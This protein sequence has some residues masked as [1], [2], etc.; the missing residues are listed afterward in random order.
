MLDQF[1]TRLSSVFG[2]LLLL[3][4]VFG[5]LAHAQEAPAN[6]YDVELSVANF[7]VGGLAREGDWAGIQVQV[8]DH[9]SETRDLVLRMS[10]RDAD[11][12]D[13]QYDRVITA[14]AGVQQSFWLYCWIP[15]RS[16]QQDFEIKAYEAID[17]GGGDSGG[18]GFRAGVMVG[19]VMVY[20][21]RLEPATV[22]FA[23]VLGNNQLGLDQYGVSVGNQLARPFGHE[24]IRSV[25][26]LG[27]ENLPDRWQ[28]LSAF[29]TIVWEGAGSAKTDPSRLSPEKARALR[30][31][32]ERGG[33][34]VIVMPSAGDPW[35]A[36]SH[37]LGQILPSIK[38]PR[39]HEGVDL[40]RYRPMI[41][42]SLNGK[43]PSNAVLYSFEPMDDQKNEDVNAA[44]LAVPVL[45]TVDGEVV[46]IR[47]LIGSGMV[48]LVGLPV[49]HP[50]LRRLGLPDPEAFWHRIIGQ[51]GAVT[52][53]EQITDE[54]QEDASTRH[55]VD[56]D[57]DLAGAID[58]TGRAVQ[59]VLFGVVV[60]VLYWIVAGPGGFG[61]LKAKGKKQHAWMFFVASIG[62]FTAMAWLG[63]TALRPKTT[64]ISHFTMLEGV[65]GQGVERTRTWMSIMLPSYGQASVSLV[66][67]E[68]EAAFR[69]NQTSDV[70]LPWV[71]PDALGT[72]TQGF[73][74]N[75]GYRIESRNPSTLRVPT[76]ATVKSFE[77]DWSGMLS[78]A[79][80]MPMPVGEPGEIGEPRLTLSG[81]T[82]QGKIVHSFP[83]GLHD[84]R[85]FVLGGQVPILQP[86]Q[87][88]GRRMIARTAVF[89]PNF[90]SQGWL[91]GEALDLGVQTK[92]VDAKS[93]ARL[94]AYFGSAL[95][96]GV[97]QSALTRSSGTIVD[98]MIA[99][100]FISQLEPPR[101]GTQNDPVG[102]KLALRRVLHGWDMGR[103]FTQ[104]TL[105][106]VGVVD[107]EPDDASPDGMPTPVWI[108]GKRVKASGKTIVSW[109]YPF[110]ANAPGFLGSVSPPA[111]EQAGNTND[112]TDESE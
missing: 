55:G 39:R 81:T 21:P 75:S 91:P 66:D 45:K 100:M 88:I 111:N 68:E 52:R 104:P 34:L 102:T 61:L 80:G 47:R 27:V 73:P 108:N 2:G 93:K 77:A 4:C 43:L 18:L 16:S 49:N 112:G 12:D 17:D 86:G 71:S 90:G 72:L 60:F 20:T 40:E 22:G 35:Y 23:G 78:Q 50:A 48:T 92:V 83:S 25:K 70:L 10:I 53:P 107:I 9:G 109:V 13:A 98:R 28:G 41:T 54:Q 95:K 84:V 87:E 99:G 89:A 26:G 56:F 5:G 106:V 69:M 103:W 8:L 110:D 85:I 82:V 30:N 42:E 97:D 79:W 38:M 44:G 96:Y 58:K 101:Y 31:W 6:G 19:K 51:R 46:A 1:R 65:Y 11:G 32:I 63:A 37:P 74:D 64:N 29:G 67:P 15:F 7:G 59:G 3:A 105:I 94:G 76:R 14:N 57:A 36:G 33:H 62:V 24:F